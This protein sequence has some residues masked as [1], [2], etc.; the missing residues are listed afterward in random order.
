MKM[1]EL[2]FNEAESCNGAIK[3][4][5]IELLPLNVGKFRIPQRS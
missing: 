2:Y 3:V 5:G 4:K 1:I